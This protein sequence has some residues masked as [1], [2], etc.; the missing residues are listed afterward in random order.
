MYNFS[1]FSIFDFFCIFSTRSYYNVKFIIR[2]LDESDGGIILILVI[3]KNVSKIPKNFIFFS[4][5]YCN[6]CF[7][8]PTSTQP[9]SSKKFSSFDFMDLIRE[10]CV[11][12]FYRNVFVS[13]IILLFLLLLIIFIYIFHYILDSIL[14][15]YYYY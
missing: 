6:K 7:S 12:V 5:I 3:S 14:P 10:L 4:S 11:C 8:L 1:F 15:F 2:I 13:F 9:I